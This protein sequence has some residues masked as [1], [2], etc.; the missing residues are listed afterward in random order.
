FP[1]VVLVVAHHSPFRLFGVALSAAPSLGRPRSRGG[2]AGAC[3]KASGVTASAR[4]TATTVSHVGL[5]RPRSRD[6]TAAAVTPAA[7]ASCGCVQ[8]RAS[9]SWRS[10]PA[11]H[12]GLI[13]SGS[14]DFRP[15]VC[16]GGN[17]IL[18]GRA[19]ANNEAA[20]TG[21]AGDKGMCEGLPRESVEGG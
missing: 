13:I 19:W 17:Y 11:N 8:P 14:P 16:V 2:H 21:T 4:H 6:F 5:F 3:A 1:R 10:R 20:G 15:P 7:P 9:R 12:S 18:T